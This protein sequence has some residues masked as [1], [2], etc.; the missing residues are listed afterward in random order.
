MLRKYILPAAWLFL[1][2]VALAEVPPEWPQWRGPT[3]G[4]AG[5]AGAK[6]ASSWDANGA[7]LL[8]ESQ[9]IDGGGY[10]SPVMAGGKVYLYVRRGYSVP[11][12][13]RI[14]PGK[15][16]GKLGACAEKVPPEL[17]A[18]I[19][20]ARAGDQRAKLDGKNVRQWADKWLADNLSDEQRKKF[21]SFAADRLTRGPA[22]WPLEALAKAHSVADRK[23]DDQAALDRWLAGSGLSEQQKKAV[24]ELVPTRAPRA[25]DVVVC[26]NAADGKTAWQAEME[27]SPGGRG[28]A[29]TVC[30]CAGKV[31]GSG[32]AGQA[33]CLDAAD[34]KVLWQAP[35]KRGETHSSFAVVPAGAAAGAAQPAARLVIGA[36]PLVALDAATGKQLWS[37]PKASPGNSSPA[38][39]L[40]GGKGYVLVNGQGK[41]TCVDANDGQVLWQVPGGGDSTPAVGGDVAVVQTSSRRD[42]GPGTLVYRISPKGAEKLCELGVTARGCSPVLDGD[43]V[44]AAGDGNSACVTVP[45]G[46]VLWE[47]KV[48]KETWASPLAAGGTLFVPVGNKELWVVGGAEG[49]AAVVA[50]LKIAFS[51]CT[52]PAVA[53]GRLYVRTPNTIRCY[54]LRAGG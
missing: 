47:G 8:W 35:L 26:L 31:Y 48:G 18:R 5:A 42:Q 14:V 3:R 13:E 52:S 2:C 32:S 11:V 40:S 50:R 33:F 25:K 16:L 17:L 19:E 21:G 10:S 54:D 45:S 39:W 34:G 22:A 7:K 27:G 41:L 1:A 6:L 15:A 20:A 53:G 43:L 29:S 4:G 9:P 30:V 38:V 12:A 46:K 36:G 37:Q 24:C 51:Q 23:F 28:P 49:K 44:Y